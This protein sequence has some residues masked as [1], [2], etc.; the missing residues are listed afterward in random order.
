MTA[1]CPPDLFKEFANSPGGWARPESEGQQFL[2]DALGDSMEF[3]GL[4]SFTIPKLNG[5]HLLGRREFEVPQDG[6]GEFVTVTDNGL[7]LQN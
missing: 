1:E 7:N 2:Y 4:T 3:T 5:V 6:Y